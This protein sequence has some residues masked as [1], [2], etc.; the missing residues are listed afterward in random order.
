MTVEV[1]YPGELDP[2][3]EGLRDFAREL[4]KELEDILPLERAD[5]HIP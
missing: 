5:Y 1:F 3:G 2:D 4:L